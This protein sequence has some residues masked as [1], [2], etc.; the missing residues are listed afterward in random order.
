MGTTAGR[1]AGIISGRPPATREVRP[2]R[3]PHRFTPVHGPCTRGPQAHSRRHASLRL[4]DI[5][6]KFTF[7]HAGAGTACE[8]GAADWGGRPAGVRRATVPALRAASALSAR[9]QRSGSAAGAGRPRPTP[10]SGSCTT[11]VPGDA[12]PGHA[13]PAP[14]PSREGL[15]PS[16]PGQ[17]CGGLTPAPDAPTHLGPSARG[18]RRGT[19]GAGWQPRPEGFS[20]CAGEPEVPP[21]RK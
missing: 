17:V 19:P 5:T 6:K 4:Q 13:Q 1:R 14:I 15:S 7:P 8:N 3:R 21:Q 12:T 2:R 16:A 11:G 18:R 9:D 10:S 20:I